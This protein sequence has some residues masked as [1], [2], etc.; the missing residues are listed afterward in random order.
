MPKTPH[1]G[2][3]YKE[4]IFWFPRISGVTIATSL[5]RSTQDVVILSFRM[6]PDNQISKVF[7]SKI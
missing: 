4:N 5:L 7:K 6:F 2:F 1:G 3:A